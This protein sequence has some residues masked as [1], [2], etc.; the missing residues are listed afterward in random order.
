MAPQRFGRIGWFYVGIAPK[1]RKTCTGI[2]GQIR[3]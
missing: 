1:T 3:R 2:L